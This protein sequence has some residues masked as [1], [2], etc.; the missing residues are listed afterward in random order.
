M[1]PRFKKIKQQFS[2]VSLNRLPD[3][4]LIQAL[5][6]C[7]DAIANTAS[8]AQI[9]E[10]SGIRF[11]QIL[12]E[13]VTRNK[14]D[15]LAT[16]ARQGIGISCIISPDHESFQEACD[17]WTKAVRQL[18]KTNTDEALKTAR[19]I[20][21]LANVPTDDSADEPPAVP[22]APKIKEIAQALIKELDPPKP[23]EILKFRP[24]S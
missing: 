11:L 17:I 1:H 13:M 8:N 10:E 7:G 15:L 21:R 18:A 2:A 4:N 16:A 19:Y 24:R 12:N 14:P 6:S 5:E 22:G 20:E 3:D 23:A 9:Q